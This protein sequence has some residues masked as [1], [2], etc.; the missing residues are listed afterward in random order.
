MTIHSEVSAKPPSKY[1]QI[2]ISLIAALINKTIKH[3]RFNK[4]QLCATAIIVCVTFLFSPVNAA[5]NDS[6][7]D[8]GHIYKTSKAN[9][10]LVFNMDDDGEKLE[11]IVL[12][13]STTSTPIKMSLVFQ[14]DV[15]ITKFS[16]LGGSG[17]ALA[18]FKCQS[19][20]KIKTQ[21]MCRNTCYVQASH[22]QKGSWAFNWKYKVNQEI[23]LAAI[24]AFSGQKNT[25][26]KSPSSEVV[27]STG[28]GSGEPKTSKLDKAKSTCTELGFTPG[29]EKHGDCVLKMLDN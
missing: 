5:T 16:L 8:I 2:F 26:V 28:D 18:N 29:A 1:F 15:C 4:N 23:S 10:R 14:D 27:S 7:F 3:V 21:F 12:V 13:G 19:G 9:Q 22:S 17:H 24:M 11:A 20:A 6:M 25:I